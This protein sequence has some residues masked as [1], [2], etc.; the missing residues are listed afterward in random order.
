MRQMAPTNITLW[1]GMFQQHM[2]VY[3]FFFNSGRDG[4]VALNLHFSG[5]CGTLSTITEVVVYSEW[6][7][8]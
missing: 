6:I 2:V 8:M 7:Y 4:G 3:W 5:W 1:L